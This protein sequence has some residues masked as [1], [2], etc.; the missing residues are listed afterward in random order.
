M[1]RAKYDLE[2][3]RSLVCSYQEGNQ[4]ALWFSAKSRSIDRV[5]EYFACEYAEAERIVLEGILKLEPE[6]FARQALQWEV[7]TDIY[8]LANYLGENWY[9]K[10]AVETE[11]ACLEEIS[12]HP[13]EE[14]LR[15]KDGRILESNALQPS[16]VS[17]ESPQ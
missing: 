4:D 8:G 12:F 14:D 6:D 2:F 7:V 11:P 16:E 5:R 17:D 1:Q 15:L 10:F 13:L 9:V 3:V